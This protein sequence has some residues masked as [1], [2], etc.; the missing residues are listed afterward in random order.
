[1]LSSILIYK[2]L[3]YNKCTNSILLNSQSYSFCQKA[4]NIN[5][6]KLQQELHVTQKQSNMFLYTTLTQKLEVDVRI[7][8]ENVNAFALFGFNLNTNVVRDSLVNISLGFE[9]FHGALVCIKCDVEIY[10]CSL[11]FIA[12]G[13]ELSGLVGEA[14]NSVFLQQ[15]LIQYRLASMH[16][17]GIV[18]RIDNANANV[19]IVDC[20]LTGSNLIES[21]YSGYIACE[22]VS[23]MNMTI[24]SFVVCV[25]SNL[26]LGNQSANITF[27][28]AVTLS[29]DVCGGQMVVYG[30]CGDSLQYAQPHSGMLTC[31][32]PFEF[33][34]GQCQC[35]YGYLLDGSV[36]VNVIEAIH[37]MSSQMLND[38][39]TQLLQNITTMEQKLQQ[40]DTSFSSNMNMLTNTLNNNNA[41]L[42][43]YILGNYS[44]VNTEMLDNMQNLETGMTGN[45]TA[46]NISVQSSI[47]ALN[48]SIAS[49]FNSLDQYIF[50]N[51]SVIKTCSENCTQ[52]LQQLNNTL[53]NISYNT[54][55]RILSYI[56]MFS[57][58]NTTLNNVTSSHNTS[59]LNQTVNSLNVVLEQ[60]L[61]VIDNLKLQLL[62][63][64]QN[65][66]FL[67]FCIQNIK[68]A[69]ASLSC[70][71]NSYV[72]VYDVTSI[73][74]QI[75]SSINFSSGHVFSSSTVIKN[76]FI[77]VFDGVYSTVQPLF[78]S[79]SIFRNIKIQ[80]GTQTVSGG[81]I[82]T[83]NSNIIVNQMNIVSRNGSQITIP[84][85]QQLNVLVQQSTISTN[86]TNL[87]V[88]LNF[89][90]SNGNITL[91]SSISGLLKISGYQL[92]GCYLSTNTVAMIGIFASFASLNL[93]WISIIPDN[94]YVGN[95]SSFL[96]STIISSNLKINNISIIIGNSINYLEIGSI[97][98][99]NS[100]NQYYQFGGVLAVFT[101]TN[102]EI[103][104]FIQQSFINVKTD[105][106]SRFGF[107]L[108]YSTSTNNNISIN[109]VCFQLNMSS[110][111]S[112]QQY[113]MVGIFGCYDGDTKLY[114][115]SILI[116]VYGKNFAHFGPISTHSSLNTQISNVITVMIVSQNGNLS[117]A[118][119]A[120]IS[121]INCVNF[122]ILNA[123]V[124]NS[125]IIAYDYAGGLI[126]YSY[127]NCKN[128]TIF[129]STVFNSTISATQSMVA[130]FVTYIQNNVTISNSVLDYSNISAQFY[131]GGFTSYCLSSNFTIDNST[132]S[133][134]RITGSQLGFVTGYN[135]GS[136]YHLINSKSIG[137][138]YIGGAVQGNCAF[139]N[140]LVP[141]GC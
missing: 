125:N 86:I 73:T 52:Q 129:N 20:N 15:S 30:L 106:V 2:Q 115:M 139:T 110:S 66:K 77:D 29:C 12:S 132:I 37:N 133:F 135:N 60:Q 43:Q 46:L 40:I 36:C 47:N 4:K 112:Q 114:N 64:N 127:A 13:K 19:T 98:S 95:S 89:V 35:E 88:N 119:A 48:N 101:F 31:D 68:C 1:M 33:V 82:L 87:L 62:C 51:I 63:I 42:E 126:G 10:N 50:N 103:N 53:Q 34:D 107:L 8:N 94:Y 72:S 54:S 138:N 58:I 39:V 71:T 41:I 28:G 24:S 61:D 3:N 5:N 141:R 14:P 123:T 85:P 80:I 49:N 69:D 32:L 81:S 21:D 137:T 44:L 22:I 121:Y 116:R 45:I 109:N 134:A 111:S 56:N 100:I 92:Q 74:N 9:V 79:Q 76:A 55:Q 122:Q 11:V 97:V 57:K 84:G 108:G 102:I 75:I 96:L 78:Q 131:V 118:V 136:T 117:I 124:L 70:N 120:L 6:L 128:L 104:S 67:D 27:N 23:Q 91:I 130:G 113:S 93:S 65:Y 59:L 140:A 99:L 17:S 25:D 38:Q 26:S 7:S 18:N 83:T 16:T 105:Y 90:M